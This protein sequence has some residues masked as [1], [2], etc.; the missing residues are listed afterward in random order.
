MKATTLKTISDATGFSVTTISRVLNGK[1]EQY[2]ISKTSADA[3]IAEA[4]KCNYPFESTSQN[5]RNKDSKTI[6]LLIPYI[7]NPYFADLASI[8]ISEFDKNG[9]SIVVIDTMEDSSRMIEGIKSMIQRKVAGI[10]V[11]PC[12]K[13]S[14]EFDTLSKRIPM[15]VLDRYYE[16][17]TLPYVVTNNY[18]GGFSATSK[19]IEKGH[20]KIA[21][22]Q[23]VSSSSPNRERVQGYIDAMKSAG[24]E[25]EINVTGN[26]FTIHNGYVETKLLLSMEERPSAI[27]ALSGTILL[28]SVKAVRESGAMIPEDI[29]YVSFDNNTF[30][31]YLMPS[32]SRI[33]QPIEAMAT[34]AVKILLDR[35]SGENHFN[36]QIR[37][38]P[39]FISGE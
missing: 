13:Y 8:I 5:L 12:G 38:S 30:L 15:V 28:G 20:R 37:L 24:L 17:S 6:G 31:D 34:L 16:E 19:L 18:Q 23:G 32:I 9:Y 22:I 10:I 3:I 39:S 26:D 25:E 2:R 35:I 4:K 36:S 27:F 14:K 29:E 11:V 21:C 1:S 7:S 33:N